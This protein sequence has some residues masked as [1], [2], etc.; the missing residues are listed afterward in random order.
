MGHD[1]DQLEEAP[2]FVAPNTVDFSHDTV[3]ETKCARKAS[4]VFHCLS[5]QS[6]PSHFV[7][8]PVTLGSGDLFHLLRRASQKAIPF[9]EISSRCGLDAIENRGWAVMK[10]EAIQRRNMVLPRLDHGLVIP[11]KGGAGN[12][13]AVGN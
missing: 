1:E 9:I 10:L 3:G 4:V 2:R 6:E 11:G 5:A 13:C 8:E 7:C 12:G